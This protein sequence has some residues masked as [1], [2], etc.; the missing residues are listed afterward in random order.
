MTKW[1][2]EI[3]KSF[4]VPF[5][6]PFFHPPLF[7]QLFLNVG[8]KISN[9]IQVQA[10]V[11]HLQRINWHRAFFVRNLTVDTNI[12]VPSAIISGQ[13]RSILI[14]RRNST[15]RDSNGTLINAERDLDLD[16]KS[17]RSTDAIRSA[18]RRDKWS[19]LTKFSLD[20]FRHRIGSVKLCHLCI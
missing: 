18:R 14:R 4:L 13:H 6:L 15:T 16:I 8:N 1:I 17:D 3:F 7:V 11:A 19:D 12:F 20:S 10:T 9:P 2:V 5:L